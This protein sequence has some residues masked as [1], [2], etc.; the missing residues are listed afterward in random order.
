M[1]SGFKLDSCILV[2]CTLLLALQSL[3]L[4]YTGTA[5]DVKFNLV[6]QLALLII[7]GVWSARVSDSLLNAPYIFV[8]SIYFWHSTFVTLHFLSTNPR[9]Q[10]TGKIFSF[11]ERYIPQ[12]IGFVGLCLVCAVLGVTWARQ[13]VLRKILRKRGAVTWVI[14]T[15]VK[16]PLAQ[17]AKALIWLSLSVFV[18]V[19]SAYMA[20]ESPHIFSGSYMSLYVDTPN[21]LSYQIYQSLK[22]MGVPI[23][24][25]VYAFASNRF[26]RKIALLVSVALIFLNL[27]IGSRSVP[28]IY[29]MALFV[30]IDQFSWRIPFLCTVAIAVGGSALSFIVDHSRDYGLGL[31][32]FDLSSSGRSVDYLHIFSNAGGV[33]RNLLRTMEFSEG[34]FWWG[35]SFVD[36]VI[37]LMP[38]AAIDPLGL[39]SGALRPSEWLIAASGDVHIGEGLGYSLVA[40]A[41]LN[42]GYGGCL[43]FSVIGGM[44]GHSFFSFRLCDNRVAWINAYIIAV[45]LSLHMRNDSA[46]YLR[47]I[48]YG[49]VLTAIVRYMS[50]SSK[51]LRPRRATL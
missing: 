47:V 19:Q 29:A 26:E 8:L 10:D 32:V 16:R 17:S 48:F 7:F 34:H 35:R 15:P 46:T 28:F 9:F 13:N 11:G 40:E 45:T 2:G 38:R 3:V 51:V 25:V 44:I 42:F 33:I 39:Y 31:Q 21:S 24:L 43:L 27:L 49:L 36:S 41:Y 30:C 4:I 20:I 12:S 37:Y 5:V 23:I 50:R 6:L 18:L 22:F 14:T 1:K